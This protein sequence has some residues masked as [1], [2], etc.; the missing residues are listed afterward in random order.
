[1]S[2]LTQSYQILGITPCLSDFK[3][4]CVQFHKNLPHAMSNTPGAA[5]ISGVYCSV[6]NLGSGNTNMHLNCSCNMAALIEE[7]GLDEDG[8]PVKHY[9]SSHQKSK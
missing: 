1:M 7:E 5:D 2:Q 6:I 9:T 8:K 4:Q 3:K